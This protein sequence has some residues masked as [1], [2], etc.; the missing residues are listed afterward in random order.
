MSV[1]CLVCLRGLCKSDLYRGSQ[2]LVKDKKE[3]QNTQ[4][5]SD[6]QDKVEEEEIPNIHNNE[7]IKHSKYKNK[8]NNT[9]N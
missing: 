9:N 6:I 8:K 4:K 3:L 5:Y 1:S 2:I 7:T